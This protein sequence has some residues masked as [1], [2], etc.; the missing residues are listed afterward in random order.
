MGGVRTERDIVGLEVGDAVGLGVGEDCA[1]TSRRLRQH[2]RAAGWQCAGKVLAVVYSPI[3]ENA[4]PV[5]EKVQSSTPVM[6]APA[7]RRR[8]GRH[9]VGM[10]SAWAAIS[11]TLV[12]GGSRSAHRATW[13]RWT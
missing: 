2:T 8:M 10:G 11:T 9:G 4:S 13:G 5:D 12:E 7:R 3:A 6:R 1:G